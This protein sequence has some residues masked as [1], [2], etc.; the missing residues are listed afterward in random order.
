MT[1]QDIEY[2]GY[3]IRT[4]GDAIG[5]GGA[6]GFRYIVKQHGEILTERTSMEDAKREIDEM[7]E[8]ARQEAVP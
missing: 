4:A 2:R 6:G 1:N 3:T 8:Q 5:F 7:I